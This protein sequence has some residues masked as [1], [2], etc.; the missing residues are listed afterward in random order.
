M[1][2]LNIKM[3]SVCGGVGVGRSQLETEGLGLKGLERC[4][5]S[6][7][8]WPRWPLRFTTSVT[9]NEQ[10]LM[11]RTPTHAHTWRFLRY[12][13][14]RDLICTCFAY[15]A[16]IHV[17]MNYWLLM[18]SV[19]SS[20]VKL[21]LFNWKDGSLGLVARIFNLIPKYLSLFTF[22]RSGL[23]GSIPATFRFLGTI[24]MLGDGSGWECQ[25]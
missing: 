1:T 5:I 23:M 21:V 7:I 19:C 24:F 16:L 20:F 6:R 12:D 17:K 3:T 18:L 4:R 10:V 11:Q 15:F 2:S 9:L 13:F 25:D 22:N 8:Y 14:N